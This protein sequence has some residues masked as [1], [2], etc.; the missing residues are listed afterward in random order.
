MCRAQSYPLVVWPSLLPTAH[1]WLMGAGPGN[2]ALDEV[3]CHD[4]L[5][6]GKVGWY[7]LDARCVVVRRPRAWPIQAHALQRPCLSRPSVA[8]HQDTGHDER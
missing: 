4:A 6:T 1:G 8:T 2:R 5:F 7:V 3:I